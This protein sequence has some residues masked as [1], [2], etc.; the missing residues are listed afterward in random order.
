[1]PR[2]LITAQVVLVTLKY[3]TCIKR[4]VITYVSPHIKI[5]AVEYFIDT[6]AGFYKCMINRIHFLG[7]KFKQGKPALIVF[8][9]R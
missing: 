5:L 3:M 4:L 9:E 1:M 8:T 6:C 2:S 7:S